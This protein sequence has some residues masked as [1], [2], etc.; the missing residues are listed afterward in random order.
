MSEWSP[1][2]KYILS[3]VLIGCLGFILMLVFS[4]YAWA[5]R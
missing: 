3:M 2:A 4:F 5:T 1:E